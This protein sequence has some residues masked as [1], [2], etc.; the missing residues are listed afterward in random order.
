MKAYLTAAL[1]AAL[2]LPA[3]AHTQGAAQIDGPAVVDATGSPITG[4][5]NVNQKFYV[6]SEITNGGPTNLPFVYIVKVSDGQGANVLLEW[7]AGEATPGQ[8]LNIAVSWAAA[9]P[10]TYTAEVF[11]WD[12]IHSQNALDASK[13]IAVP[14]S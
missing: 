4:H 3:A 12:G 10:D 1:L 6:A 11:L 13:S 8:T 14:V 7:F 5:I 9:A 2:L